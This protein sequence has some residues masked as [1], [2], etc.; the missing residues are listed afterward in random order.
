MGQFLLGS[1]AEGWRRDTWPVLCLKSPPAGHPSESVLGACVYLC[2]VSVG[3][4]CLSVSVCVCVS[5]P[6]LCI[7]LDIASVLAEGLSVC[8]S[9]RGRLPDFVCSVVGMSVC[10]AV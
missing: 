6:C 4:F 8:P 2:T 1:G 5:A 7:C 10:A 9:F 3:C